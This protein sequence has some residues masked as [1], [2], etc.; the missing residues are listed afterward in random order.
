MASQFPLRRLQ[1]SA[2]T[3]GFFN[4]TT[5][6]GPSRHAGGLAQTDKG[7]AAQETS[8]ARKRPRITNQRLAEQ[9]R[10]SPKPTIAQT[11]PAV[12]VPFAGDY[13]GCLWN[14]QALFAAKAKSGTEA[15]PR[16]LLEIKP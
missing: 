7:T 9:T 10:A 6:G 1:G 12:E 14:A 16:L 13:S 8:P 15:G 3:N 5:D 2:S 4:D 11:S